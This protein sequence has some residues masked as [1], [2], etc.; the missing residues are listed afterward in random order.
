MA[1]QFSILLQSSFSG[2]LGAALVLAILIIAVI[3][4]RLIGAW[5][6]RINEV[7]DRQDQIIHELRKINNR[8]E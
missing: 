3:V 1:T 4:L 2:A 7:I 6:L 8:Y 5:M